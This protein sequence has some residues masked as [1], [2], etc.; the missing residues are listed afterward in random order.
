MPDSASLKGQEQAAAGRAP[1]RKPRWNPLVMHNCRSDGRVHLSEVVVHICWDS[2][3][4]VSS[5]IITSLTSISEVCPLVASNLERSRNQ[6]IK[7]LQAIGTA[8]SLD[9]FNA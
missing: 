4:N 9:L 2:H 8:V 3:L 6:Y 1:P 5:C 7:K